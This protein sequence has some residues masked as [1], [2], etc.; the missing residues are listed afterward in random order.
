[1]KYTDK[2][3][4]VPLC[5]VSTASS[6][7]NKT[8]SWRFAEPQF[9]DRVSPCNQQCPAGEDITGY[10]YLAGQE[11]FEEAWRLIM[12]ENP[13]PATMGRVCFHTCEDRCN[14]KDHDE[15]LAI[16][17][18]ERFIGDYGLSQ[19][20][21]VNIAGEIKDKKVAI[22]GA[23]PGGLSAAYHLRRMGYNVH[24][25][26]LNE[27]PGGLLRY[28][29]PSYR[30]PKDVIDGEIGRLYDMGIEF[31][32][33]TQV[34]KDISW[35]DLDRDFNAVFIAIGAYREQ[36][37][38]LEGMEKDGIYKALEF[39]RN[40]N[41]GNKPISGGKIAVIGG[42]NS[43]IDCAMVSRRLGAEVTIVYRRSEAEMPA[44]GE[45]IEMARED[46][47]DFLFLSN[48][49]EVYGNS[50]I[51]GLKLEKMTLG[52][53]DSSGRRRPVPTGEIF[54]VDFDGMILAVGESTDVEGLPSSIDHKEGV[55]S[56]DY[57]SQTNEPKYFAGG[58]IIDIPHTVTNA[59]GAGKR[60]AVG[61]DRFLQGIKDEGNELDGFRWGSEGNISIAGLNG[62]RLFPRKNPAYEVVD[63]KELNNFYFDHRPRIKISSMPS[64]DRLSNFNEVVKSQ[65][66]DNIVAEARR[67]F[68]CGS[69]T[70][71]GNCYT[72][73]PD[74]AV[75]KDPAGYGFIIDL[76]YCKGCGIC[77]NECPRGAMKMKYME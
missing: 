29:I 36:F 2:Q 6:L 35:D 46:G 21:K 51:T 18:V 40:V 65:S 61:I 42:G 10:M 74:N 73:C 64:K 38:S 19:G 31:K 77:V 45:E 57:M 11:R 76:D 39:L 71:C 8:G 25:F 69:C 67:C 55:V 13:F 59:I 37:L 14:R 32:M 33:E 1:M 26:D 34:G 66:K 47:V 24:V 41:K 44:H 9:I 70:E 62:V 49:V 75:K 17:T 22:A 48:P 63:Q 27:K 3:V 23:G 60:A 15:A 12:E 28:G 5:A 16:H 54:D 72:F 53:K 52:E 20:L 56:T 7:L 58:D 4:Q 43:A 30:L 68:N 50:K